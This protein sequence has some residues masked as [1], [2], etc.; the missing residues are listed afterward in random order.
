MRWGRILG[1]LVILLA[2]CL[3]PETMT[4]SSPSGQ[5][6]YKK[7]YS[8]GTVYEIVAYSPSMN[9][10]SQAID[11]A[12]MAIAAL[13]HMMSNYDAQSDLSRL[14]REAHFHAVRVPP[15]LFQVIQDSLV[16][17]RASDGKYD[18]T[19]APLVDVWKSAMRGGEPPSAARINRLRGCV[20]YRK[21]QLIP[22]DRIEFHSPC[23]RIDLGSIAKGYAVDRAVKILRSQNIQSA[24]INAG[25]STL[26]GMGAP[27]GRAGWSIRLRDPSGRV[28]PEVILRDDSVSTSEQEEE[29]LI[30]ADEF[31]HIIEP[32]TGQ[33]VRSDF[34]V[35]VVAKTG[36][37]TD[38]LSTT[39]FL[40]GPNN[41]AQLVRKLPDVAAIWV[42]P[43]GQTKVAST[44]PKILLH[45]SQKE[46]P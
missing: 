35:S 29:S 2:L 40:M 12:F 14:N 15:D 31:G 28:E 18:V 45:Q 24:L 37:A 44:G 1:G 7:Q 43:T 34:A 22:T 3:L 6:V 23:L 17:S 27:P 21:V 33:P 10:A 26:Y 25:G 13:D 8:M 41:G 9:R 46:N 36:T 32:I 20:G 5:F 38:G 11:A 16:Y 19:V 30:D 42:S 39:L 4:A